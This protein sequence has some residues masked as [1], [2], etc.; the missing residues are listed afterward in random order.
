MPLQAVFGGGPTYNGFGNGQG[1]TVG[2]YLWET[3][4]VHGVHS[5][6]IFGSAPAVDG[7]NSI[8]M[9]SRDQSVIFSVLYIADTEEALLPLWAADLKTM[10]GP[11]DI[12]VSGVTFQRCFL[13]GDSSK[14]TTIEKRLND[15]G[16]IV[17][18]MMGVIRVSGKGTGEN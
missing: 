10:V 16:A 3:P 9:G 18:M 5:E 4:E 17:Y 15:S 11:I 8:F 6:F 12:S 1:Y 7:M 2:R 13:E 14:N